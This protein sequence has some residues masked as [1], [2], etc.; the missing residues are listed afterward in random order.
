MYLEH[1]TLV[2][3]VTRSGG[4]GE[5]EEE[6]EEKG[7]GVPKFIFESHTCPD[8]LHSVILRPQSLTRCLGWQA[9]SFSG[10]QMLNT[11]YTAKNKTKQTQLAQS[12]HIRCGKVKRVRRKGWKRK[13]GK[14][15][16]CQGLPWLL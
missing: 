7:G 6:E 3:G 8:P 5:E 12:R 9:S 2:S 1:V 10:L 4:G 15:A 16:A 14:L 11:I 13:R